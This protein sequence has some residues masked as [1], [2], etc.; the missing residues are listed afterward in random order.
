MK[1]NPP[2]RNV[3]LL[4]P[5]LVI[6]SIHF[7][8][9]SCCSVYCF[10]NDILSRRCQLP[11]NLSVLV[12]IHS[13]VHQQKGDSLSSWNPCENKTV[14]RLTG[15]KVKGLTVNIHKEVW[16][17]TKKS[18]WIDRKPKRMQKYRL[19]ERWVTSGQGQTRGKKREKN[20][21]KPQRS[22][23]LGREKKKIVMLII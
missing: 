2:V 23:K 11:N 19:R 16:T 1:V 17:C 22:L 3:S 20:V 15:I 9:I 13:Q 6:F 4:S 14:V 21:S 12:F 7:M 18:K 10:L 5:K 8:D